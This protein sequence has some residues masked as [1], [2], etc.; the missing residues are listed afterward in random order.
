M[1][2]F[3][4]YKAYYIN[5]QTLKTQNKIKALKELLK[6]NKDNAEK[7]DNW[8]YNEVMTSAQAKAFRENDFTKFKKMIKKQLER[9]K[10]KLQGEKEKALANYNDIAQLKDIKRAVID[11]EWSSGR[12]SMGAYQTMATA[13]VEYMDGTYKKHITGFTG[14]CGYDK[15]STSF[16]EIASELLKVVFV[17][18]GKKILNDENAHYHY[19]AGEHLYYQYGVGLSSYEQFFKNLGYKVE[20]INHRNEN[21]TYIITKKGTK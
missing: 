11:I 14:G 7:Y 10:S 18:H 3:K 17:K 21:T 4:N 9:E 13:S 16:S 6:A 8:R 5:A 15:P 12:R 2:K 20:V 19:Y 1:E